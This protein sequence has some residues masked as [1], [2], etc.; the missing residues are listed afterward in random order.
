MKA[1]AQDAKVLSILSKRKGHKAWREM[2]GDVLREA[3][4][5]LIAEQVGCKMGWEGLMMG[6]CSN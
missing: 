5:H 2:Q 6:R 1:V 4:V 3:L